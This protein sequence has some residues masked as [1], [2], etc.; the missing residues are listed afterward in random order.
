MVDIAHSIFILRCDN[1]VSILTKT[2]E[3]IMITRIAEWL[4]GHRWWVMV[5]SLLLIAILAMGVK[6]LSFSI[7]Y[8]YFFDKGNPELSAYEGLKSQYTDTDNLVFIVSPNSG[9]VFNREVLTVVEKL[10]ELAWLLPYA[11]R[12]DSISNFQYTY[13]EEDD[14][15]VEPL[16]ENASKLSDEGISKI[17]KVALTEPILLNQFQAADG[18][19]TAVFTTFNLPNDSPQEIR[20][21]VTQAKLIISELHT[22]FPNVDISP[23]G[24]TMLSYTYGQASKQDITQLTPLMFL[25]ILLLV[26]VLTR[27]VWGTVMTMVI[28]GLVNLA[29]YGAIGWMGV[30]ITTVTAIAPTIIM[31]IVVAHAVHVIETYSQEW[32]RIG[33]KNQALVNSIVLNS[34]PIFITSL[35]TLIGFLAMNF[36]AVPPYRDLGNLIA[37]SVC[38]AFVLC[39]GFLPAVLSLL[40]VKQRSNNRFSTWLDRLG[41]WVVGHRKVILAVSSLLFIASALFVP[42]IALNEK[43]VE[44]FDERFEFRRDSDFFTENI[45]GV[46]SIEYGITPLPKTENSISRPKT[47]A[48]VDDFVG[49]LRQQ[50]EIRHVFSI[51]DTFKRLNKNL[52]EDQEAWYRLPED[53]ELSAQY[54]LLYQLSLP[55]GLDLNNQLTLKKDGTRVVVRFDD[56]NSEEL[57]IMEQRIAQWWQLNGIDYQVTGASTTLMF[58]HIVER[59]V[60]SM[61]SGTLVA[62]VFITLVMMVALRSV[63]L[64]LI[65]MIPNVVPIIIGLGA[66]YFLEGQ[67]GMSFAVVVVLTL[68]IIVDDTVHFLSKYR[69]GRKTLGL[70]SK[71]A[72]RHTFKTVGVALCIT[73][74]ALV[75][76]FL[77][78]S[79]SGFAR[80]ADMGLMAAITISIALLVDLFLLPALLLWFDGGSYGNAENSVNEVQNFNV[81][82]E[83]VL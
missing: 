10:T 78:L 21:I 9:D 2:E 61:I 62:F 36:N 18:K 31:A 43:F 58:T 15:I 57:I 82:A 53:S 71:M 45:S 63:K 49:W 27:S 42:K 28:I 66:W 6:R 64:G 54:L 3:F 1:S 75:A 51:T 14:L 12:V 50:T 29:S 74:F 73:T 32:V 39:L 48:K 34:P 83:S 38:L 37:I 41:V 72:I 5:C 35:T 40:P 4:I 11:N 68:G 52:H 77:V 22:D 20:D 24:L 47:L 17:R 25:F 76:G 65:S 60:T 80:N 44:Q 30:P 26:A 23:I 7:D 46:Y 69:H 55:Y 70:A 13:A 8:E 16:V 19:S 67:V 33:N 79:L 81:D 59:A 56:L